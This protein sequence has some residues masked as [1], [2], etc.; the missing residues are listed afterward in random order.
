L[1]R[2]LDLGKPLSKKLVA[3]SKERALRSA[4]LG[5]PSVWGL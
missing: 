2:K 5:L 4:F 3:P 1:V